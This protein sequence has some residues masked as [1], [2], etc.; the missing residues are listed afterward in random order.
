MCEIKSLL[1]YK[2]FAVIVSIV[3]AQDDFGGGEDAG[4][5]EM[6]ESSLGLDQ[7]GAAGPGSPNSEQAIKIKSINHHIP[8][9]P[10][11]NIIK[12]PVPILRT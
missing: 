3:S 8:K 2:L 5:A 11:V 4:G 7:A 6:D 12:I 9:P 1:F 10:K